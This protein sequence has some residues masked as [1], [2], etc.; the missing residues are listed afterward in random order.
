VDRLSDLIDRRIAHQRKAGAA[1]EQGKFS[2]PLG[3]EG[4]IVEADETY[5]GKEKNKHV[6]KRNKKN[7]GGMGKEAAF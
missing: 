3:G 7:I 6:K 1:F 2:G 5:I 4:K